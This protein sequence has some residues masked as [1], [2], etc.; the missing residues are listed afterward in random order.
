MHSASY[1]ATE[2]S[3]QA[4]YPQSGHLRHSIHTARAISGSGTRRNPASTHELVNA[5]VARLETRNMVGREGWVRLLE[6]GGGY[7]WSSRIWIITKLA[8]QLCDGEL[9]EAGRR[10]MHGD[11]GFRNQRLWALGKNLEGAVHASCSGN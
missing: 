8:S 7:T 3:P 6:R 11:K 5:E 1:H 4:L 10:G 9:Q 2:W